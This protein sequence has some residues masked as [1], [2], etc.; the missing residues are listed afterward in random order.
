MGGTPK[1]EYSHILVDTI[2]HE[3]I[4]YRRS[5]ENF[6]YKVS[7]RSVQVFKQY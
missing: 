7:W 6:N 3:S 1:K 4:Q 2:E 5:D